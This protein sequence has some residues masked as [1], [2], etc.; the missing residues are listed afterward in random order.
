MIPRGNIL[1]SRG[2]KTMAS[3]FQQWPQREVI[4]EF[5]YLYEMR[6]NKQLPDMKQGIGR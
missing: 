1:S 5:E 3:D 6:V 2:G 4:F